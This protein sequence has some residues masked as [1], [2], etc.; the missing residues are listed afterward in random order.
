MLIDGMQ[1]L[2]SPDEQMISSMHYKLSRVLLY[3]LI[4]KYRMETYGS[5]VVHT[6]IKCLPCIYGAKA[7]FQIEKYI[8]GYSIFVFNLRDVLSVH[9]LVLSLGR[10][11][12]R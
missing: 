11:W 5:I 3:S 12:G 9:Y 7:T 10:V 2:S 4:P 6:Y 1:Y 8:I